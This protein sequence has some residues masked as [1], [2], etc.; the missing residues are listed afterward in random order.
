MERCGIGWIIVS[1]WDPS[2]GYHQQDLLTGSI[3]TG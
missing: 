3:L 2:N 1:V